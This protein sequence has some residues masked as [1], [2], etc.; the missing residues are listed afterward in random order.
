M[1]RVDFL[2]SLTLWELG[3]L[4]TVGVHVPGGVT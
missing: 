4:Q 3:R 2:K 1:T